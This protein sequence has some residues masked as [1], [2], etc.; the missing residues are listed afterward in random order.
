MSSDQMQASVD[1]MPLM[2]LMAR[3]LAEDGCAWDRAQTHQSL[4]KHVIEEACEVAEAIDEE[5]AA[6]LCDELGDLL[7]Q[8]V[9]H[10]SIAKTF[11]MQDVIDGICEKMTRRHPHV[12]LKSDVSAVD[13]WEAIKATERTPRAFGDL[14]ADLPALM[15]A[16]KLI[17]KSRQPALAS[18]VL[19]DIELG[20][21]LLTLC[22][23]AES[24]GLDAEA[25]LMAACRRYT[26]SIQASFE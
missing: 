13:G 24:Q 21:A 10:A 26:G 14:P 3:L 16:Q 8:I 12:F 9:F 25:A 20:D 11:D 6:H 18:I 22:H 15:R 5:D 19:T 7:Y 1:I 23:A 17:R 4:R 2:Q